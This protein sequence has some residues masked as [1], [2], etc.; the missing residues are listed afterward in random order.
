MTREEITKRVEK[1]TI[2]TLDLRREGK[3]YKEIANAL[4]FK[5]ESWVAQICQKNGLAGTSAWKDKRYEE[6][7]KYKAEGHTMA[8]VAEKFGINV[9]TAQMVC[10]GIAPQTE[11]PQV[12]KNQY[13]SGEF[14]REA[15]AIRYIRERTPGFEYAGNYTGVDGF[16]DLK[17]KTCGATIRKSFISV[18]HGCATCQECKKTEASRREEKRRREKEAEANYKRWFKLSNLKAEQITL[19]TCAG[20]G[21]LYVPQR[22]GLK[23]C[24][25]ECQKK[26]ANAMGKDKRLRLIGE[27]LV[28]KD[29]DLRTLYER[30]GGKCAICGRECDWSD[31]ETR[32]DGTFIAGNNYP[33]IDHIVPL[34]RGGLHAW[35]NVQLACRICNSK[36]CANVALPVASEA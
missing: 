18:R 16:V 7:R 26:N 4:G 27:N 25:V 32:E 35:S 5:T 23:Y 12:Y 14:D 34:S 20:C 36:K 13:T 19:Q 1:N 3:T 24:S 29:I 33:S 9:G 30:D 21:V 2:R 28:D 8:E 11:R 6:Y 15:N 17:C 22:R 31:C 10:K